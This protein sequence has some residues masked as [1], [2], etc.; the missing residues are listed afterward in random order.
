MLDSV[1]YTVRSLLKVPGFSAVVVLTLALEIGANAAMFSALQAVLLNPLPFHDPDRI[2][3][4]GEYATSIDTQFVSPITYDDWKIRNEAFSDLAAF[5]YW[6]TVNLE[7]TWA[8]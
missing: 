4:L 3:V 6:G 1:R 5:R 8:A 7:D 2:V